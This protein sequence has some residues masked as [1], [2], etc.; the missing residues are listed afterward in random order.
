[1]HPMVYQLAIF[2][3]IFLL[4]LALVRGFFSIDAANIDVGRRKKSM[5]ASFIAR[6][7]VINGS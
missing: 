2:A 4:L 1:M 7:I 3:G 6:L 5:F